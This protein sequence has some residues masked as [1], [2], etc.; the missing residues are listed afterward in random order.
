LPPK[1]PGQREEP[2]SAKTKSSNHPKTTI[3]KV[4]KVCD[5]SFFGEEDF[6]LDQ[7]RTLTATVTSI[8]AKV[9]Q[10]DKKVN[11]SL[12]FNSKSPSFIYKCTQIIKICLK[13]S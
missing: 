10:L 5:G 8:R 11:N 12:I 1:E 9:L 3:I 2:G 6:F 7:A 4:A 13:K